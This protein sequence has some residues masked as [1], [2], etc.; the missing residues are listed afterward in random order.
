MLVPSATEMI[1]TN[2][3][4][5]IAYEVGDEIWHTPLEE[6]ILAEAEKTAHHFPATIS[7]HLGQEQL[8]GLIAEDMSAHLRAIGD[9]YTT[10]D[11]VIYTL[12]EPT[13]DR[14]ADGYAPGMFAEPVVVEATFEQ[15]SDYGPRTVTVRWSDGTTSQPMRWYTDE[16]LFSEGDLV[17]RTERQICSLHHRRDRDWLQS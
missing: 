14:P 3:V 4:D 15:T 5:P 2:N 7:S 13:T 16:I 10:V 11:G 12:R 17:G 1:L 9:T 6:A 8:V